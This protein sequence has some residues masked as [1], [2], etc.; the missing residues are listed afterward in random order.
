DDLVPDYITHFEDG[1]FYGWPWYY[2]GGHYD[3]EHKGKHPELRDKVITPDVL[4]Q[5]HFASLEMLFY[6]GNQFPGEYHGD[7]FAAEHGSWNRHKRS[8]YEVIRVPLKKGRATGEYEDFLTGFTTD[9][10]N[11]WGRPVG[12]AVGSDGSLFVTD[13]ASNSIWR[14]SYAGK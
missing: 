13:D 2:M 14:V 4:L 12:V 1:G 5:P 9:D 11:V 7:V 3:P 8:G 10:G 6:E